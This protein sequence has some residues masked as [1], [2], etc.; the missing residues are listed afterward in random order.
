MV[1]ET[2]AA[3]RGGRP[4]EV[5]HYV[6]DTG[7]LVRTRRPSVVTV[8][9]VASRWISV[10]R[11]RKQEMLW[12]T[13]V[14]RA[15]DSTDQVITVSNSSAADVQE[16]F[17][18]ETGRLTTIEH[19]IDLERFSRRAR[20]SEEIASKLPERFALYL[21]N[22]EPRKNLVELVAAF[23]SPEVRSMGVKLVIAGKPAWNSEDSMRAIAT[24]PDV[25]R[26][27]FVSDS[28]RTALMQRCEVF[29]FPSLYEGF[30][31]PVVEAL[32]AGAVVVTSERGSLAEV[33]GPSIRFEGLERD[34]LAAGVVRALSDSSARRR[35]VDQGAQWAS[36][37]TWEVSVAKHIEVYRKALGA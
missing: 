30:G 29:V 26:L 19:G 12:R 11:S 31:F 25:V 9:G 17:G 8:H 7:P 6:A 15:V 18:V 24:S 1:N 37:F 10:A 21:G 33:A 22:I 13:R 5:L 34:A 32:A 2:L 27:G 23:A 36:R 4:G 35:C 20:L 16:V 28:D 14:Q 3:W